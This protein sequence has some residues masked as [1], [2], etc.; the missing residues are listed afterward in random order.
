MKKDK[1]DLSEMAPFFSKK[2]MAV[3]LVICKVASEQTTRLLKQCH[4]LTD[5]TKVEMSGHETKVRLHV[6]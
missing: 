1:Y 3:K 5:K 2:N 6:F 4:F